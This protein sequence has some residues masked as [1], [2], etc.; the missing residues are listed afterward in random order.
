MVCLAVSDQPDVLCLQEL[1]LWSLGRLASWT[2]MQVF[3]APTLRAPLG[4]GLGRLLTSFSYRLLRSAVCGQA[5]AI[6]VARALPAQNLG[7]TRVSRPGG[8]PRVCQAIRVDERL[9]VANVHLSES[10]AGDEADRALTWLAGLTEPHEP[11]V[12]AGDFNARLD[13]PGFTASGPTIDGVLVRGAAA[14]EL[15]V[16]PLDRRRQNG[17][18]LS[19]HAPVELAVS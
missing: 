10:S 3:P 12:L 7:A 13:L 9:V 8:H 16:W 11:L 5:N 4:A 6:L 18:V 17:V 15:G 2:E 1:P 19:D 14:S